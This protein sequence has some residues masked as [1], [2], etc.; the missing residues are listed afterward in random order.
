M[1]QGFAFEFDPPSGWNDF[2]DGNRFVFHGPEEQEL[3]VSGAVIAGHGSSASY[4]E[5]KDDLVANAI[6]A[7]KRAV[8]D[9]DVVIKNEITESVT[10][11]NLRS[12]SM[13]AETRDRAIIFLQTAVEAEGGVL[14]ATLEAPYDE[15]ARRIFKDF[16]NGVRPALAE[17]GQPV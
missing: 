6:Q 7:M 4:E 16:I 1:K 10:A 13:D 9:P 2:R 17:S 5:I 14:L 3:I 12:W 8:D 15:S 11:Q